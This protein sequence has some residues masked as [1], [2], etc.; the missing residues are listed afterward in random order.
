ML[1]PPSGVTL[2]NYLSAIK[3]N[4]KTHARLR[5][6]NQGIMFTDDDIT[7]D[8]GI[9]LSSYF[10]AETNLT[11]GKAVSNTL[12]VQL[13]RN[14]NKTDILNWNDEFI[15]EL[16]VEIS[17]ATKWVTIGYYT[18]SKPDVVNDYIVEFTAYDRMAKFNK[19]A[20]KFLNSQTYPISMSTLYNSLCTYC[21]VTKQSGDEIS[22]I[23]S[24]T[25]SQNPFNV[26]SGMSC[27]ELLAVIA[28]ANGCYAKIT[29]TGYVVLKWFTNQTSA[30]T[31]TK[32]DMYSISVSPDAWKLQKRWI[33]LEPNTWQS[34]E[35]MTWQQLEAVAAAYVVDGV[36]LIK[37]EDDVGV[38]VPQTATEGN[39]YTIVDNPFLYD[40]STSVIQNRLLLLY[41]RLKTIGAYVPAQ[42]EAIGNWMVESGDIIKL[43]ISTG[44]IVNY[45]IFN[46]TLR[47]NRACNDSY[48]TTGELERESYPTE[49]RKMISE[50]GKYHRF[51]VDIDHFRSEVADEF[52]GA[53]SYIDQTKDNIEL[54]VG[55]NY[56]DIKSGISI[57]SE[58]ITVSGSQFVKILSGGYIEIVSGGY[59]KVTTNNFSIDSSQTG[60][61]IVLRAGTRNG[62]VAFYIT[63]NGNYYL[64]NG[65]MM[66]DSKNAQMSI[67]EG[68][69]GTSNYT[70]WHFDTKGFYAT[71]YDS[72][73]SYLD[74]YEFGIGTTSANQ[75]LVQNR[76]PL[77]FIA[78]QRNSIAF[79]FRRSVSYSDYGSIYFVE[80][81]VNSKYVLTMYSY[82]DFYIGYGTGKVNT[83]FV[84]NLGSSTYRTDYIY[85]TNINT[86]GLLATSVGTSASPVTSGYFSSIYKVTS[87]SG[88]NAIQIYSS[89]GN[90]DIRAGNYRFSIQQDGNMVLYY[91]GGG[92][93]ND[94]WDSG[95]SGKTHR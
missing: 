32:R 95:T 47:W 28:E 65:Q 48:E 59:F 11:F 89:L 40:S 70:L 27:A 92:V 2:A 31:V 3:A 33:D 77:V 64:N 34:L 36:H 79:Q 80:S 35:G 4:N 20:D 62:N 38:T 10:N 55:N 74:Y 82:D 30:Y 57:E 72:N 37:T 63:A 15:F 78:I 73:P 54:W 71:K 13:I 18:P 23:M 9:T 7:V 1:T 60:D 84:T 58:G 81:Y 68:V 14:V 86:V 75:T 90:I 87:I 12:R 52:E 91:V 53:Y 76:Y 43:E 25:L 67:V 66:I 6:T 29:N 41:N 19:P 17:G 93:T 44:N 50:G 21:G 56:Y 46:R 51:I 61:S 69:S 16:G 26:E 45:P 39:L 83:I 42:V 8:G 49:I 94:I 5:F 24:S 85:A 22:T 88:T